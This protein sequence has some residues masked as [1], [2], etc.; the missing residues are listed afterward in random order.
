MAD[1][2]KLREYLK[3]AVADVREAR[4]RLQEVEDRQQEPIAIIGMGCHYPGNANTPDEL[5]HLITTTTD[6]IT[7]F[8]TNRG[9]HLDTLYHPDPDHPGTTYTQH[10]GFLHNADQFDAEFFNM[11]PREATA[12]DPQQRL[13]LHTAWETLEHAG[14]NPTTLH[15]T[16]T[17][18]FTGAMYS[19][20]GS[21]PDLPP[22]G[23][24]GHLFSGSAGSIASGRLAYTLGL[25]GPVV[26]VDTACSSSLVALHLAATAL[27]R[28]ECDLALAGGV[29]VMST[30]V[31]FVEFSRLRGL[32]DDGRCKSFSAHADGTGWSEGVGLLLVE[33]LTDALRH[34]HRVLAVV[35]GSAVNS[36][37]ASNGLTA[38]SG[39]AQERVIRRA[40]DAAGLR[41]AD[42]D[43]I[44]AHGTGT[45]LG[46]PIEAE[47]LAA[48]YGQ[49]HSPD[50]PAWLGSLKSNIGHTQAAAGVGG[51]IKVVQ[52]IRHGLLPPTLHADE[53]TPHVDWAT[54]GLALLTEARPWPEREGPR[55][56]AV[57][58]F[59]FG[60]TNAHVV[61][62]QAPE[63]PPATGGPLP[64][65]PW[66][67]SA[68]TADGLRA[69]VDRLTEFLREQ[70]DVEAGDVALSLAHRGS[71]PVRAVATGTDRAALLAALA[72]ATPTTAAAGGRTAF[73]FTGQGA[74]HAGM[75]RE[76]REAFPVFRAAFDEVCAALDPLLPRPLREVVDSGDGLD[77]TGYTQ[78]ALFA[79]ETA[80]YRLLTSWGITADLVAGHSV[81]ELTAA[82]VSGTLTLHD[83]ATLVAARARLMQALP[84]G[85]AMLAVEADEQEL[86]GWL[87]EGLDVAA[88]NGPRAVVL[89]GD[90]DGIERARVE[91]AGRGRRVR[92]LTVS[93]AFH[94]A[95]MD[96]M[97]PALRQTAAT[98]SYAVPEIPAVSTVTGALVT[99]EWGDPGYW[100]GQ[101]RATVRFADAVATLRAQGATTLLEVGPDA[102][103][104]VL[105]EGA[106]P[107]CR[108]D[109]PE[110]Q[111]VVAAAGALWTRG[112]SVDWPAYFADA[113]VN[114]VDLPPYAFDNRRYW[115][116]PRPAAAD[117]A[118]LGLDPAGHPL[119]GAVVRRADTDEVLLTGRLSAD[120][121]PWLADHLLHGRVVVPGT[122]LL[123][124]AVRAADE[125]GLTTVGEL[126]LLAPLVVPDE[127]AAQVQVVVGPTGDDGSRRV[128][129]HARTVDTDWYPVATG[130]L[131]LDG[132]S[133]PEGLPHWPP[134]G[135]DEVDLTGAYDR[136]VAAGYT[137]GPAFRG[138]RRLWRQG[139]VRYAEVTV[140]DPDRFTIHPAL[141]DAALHPLLPGVVDD[142][143]ARMPFAWAGVRVRAAGATTLRVRLTP[144][145][146]DT[147]AVLVADG[148]GG[149]VATVDALSLRPL[150]VAADDDGPG[151]PGQLWSLRWQPADPVDPGAG[152]RW[153]LL[154]TGPEVASLAYADP[155]GTWPVHAELTELAQPPDVLIAVTPSDVADDVVAGTHATVSWA[156]GVSRRFLADDRY[157]D[158][159]LVVVT[160]GAVAAR[161][162]DSPTLTHAA[163]W[164]LLRSAQTE[165]PGRLT[166][167]DLDDDA[168]AAQLAGAVAGGEPQVAIRDGQLL[169]P[170][171]GPADGV[172]V[173][174]REDGATAAQ[175]RPPRFDEG[176][177]LV[178]GGTGVLGAMV[179][180]HLVTA[181]GARRL[182]LVSRA[183]DRAEGVAA[184][185]DELTALGAEVSFAGCDVADRDALAEVL[186]AVPSDRPL[187]AVVHTAGVTDDGVL[188]A[189][190]AEQVDAVLRPKVDAAWHLHQLTLDRELSAFVLYSSLAGLVGTA[191]QANYAA[192]N[193]FL[194]ALAAHR[195]AAGLPAVSLAWGL[196]EQSSGLTGRLAEADLRRLARSGLRPL[197]SAAG[198]AL[199]DQALSGGA[200]LYAATALDLGQLR[201]SAEPPV[202]LRGLVPAGRPSARAS[203]SPGQGLG[204]QLAALSVTER[205]RVVADL[206]RTRLAGVLG[207]ADAVALV[208]E[209]PL[210]ELG[211]DSLTAVELRNQL[212]AATGLTLPTTL[213][214]DHP[215]VGALTR[216]L[217]DRLTNTTNTTTAVT[218]T[219]THTTDE[220]IAIIGMGCHYP[221]NANT[222]DEL[223]HLITT[224]TDAITTFP[225]N[226]GWHLDTLYHPDPD[227]PGTTY[228]QHGG[229]LHNADQFDAEFFNM[230]PREATAT[231]PQQRLLLHTAWETLE[232]AGINPTTLHGTNTGVF[233]GTMYSDYGSRLEQLPQEL[234]G[235]LAG[236]SAASVAS[237]RI[238]YTLGLQ[239]PAITIDTA[240]S[241]SLV[242]LHLAATALRNHECDLALTGGATIMT[243]PHT[244]TEFARQRG[245]APD[246]RC[247]PF[248]THAD[249]TG[250]SEGAGLLLLQRLTDAQQ[251]GHHI[252]AIIRG[253]AINQDGASNGLTAPNG[254]AQQ[255]VIHQALHNA[256]LQP[257]DITLIEA[258]GT[259]TRLGDPIEAQALLATYGQHRDQPLW[260]GSL[261]SNL[262]HTQAAAG[263]G[264]IIKVIE[265]IRHATLPP[266]LHA[267][268]PTPHVDWTTGNIKLL[269]HA[270]PWPDTDRPRRA[271]VSSFGI[272]GTNAHVILE[273]PPTPPTPPPPPTT[274]PPPH[275]PLIISAHNHH[276]LTQQATRLHHHLTNHP[277][278]NPTDVAYSLTRRAALPVR[279]VVVGADREEILAG[280]GSVSGTVVPPQVRTAF[281]FTGQGAQRVGM[282][283]ELRETFPVFRAAFDEVCAALDPLLPRPLRDVVDSGDGLDDTGYTQPALFAFEVALFRLLSSWGVTPDFVAGHSIGELA[284]AHVAGVLSLTDAA[285]LV[286]AR[287]RLMQDLPAGGAMLAV[288]ATEAEVAEGQPRL[289][290]AAV[291]GP[292]S[293]VLAGPEAVVTEAEASWSRRGRRVR[294]LAVSHAFHSSLMTPMLE[295]FAE[296]ADAV[297]YATPRIPAVST[298]TGRPVRDEWSDG[299]YWTNQIRSTV[300][301]A[302]AVATLGE[303]G[304]TT[305][306]EIGPDTTLAALVDGAVATGHR[307][308]SETRSLVS[309]V[310][311]AWARGVPVDWAAWFAGTG[312]TRVELPRYAFQ[313][314]SYWAVAQ[315]QADTGPGRTATGHPLLG[316][317]VALAGDDLTFDSRISRRD[318]PWLEEV[319]PAAAL[320]ELVVEAGGRGGTPLLEQLTLSGP[321]VLPAEDTLALQVRVATPDAQGRRPVSVYVRPGDDGP[322]QVHGT[323]VLAPEPPESPTAAPTGGPLVAL[324]E[325]LHDEAGRYRLHPV[326]FDAAVHSDLL[327]VEAGTVLVPTGWRGV[328]LRHRGPVAVHADVTVLDERR[329]RVRL[330]DGD[331]DL[332]GTVDE[333][334][335][336][337]VAPQQL[338][339]AAPALLALGW[340]PAEMSTHR[341][342]GATVAELPRFDAPVAD[343]VH[344]AAGW[345]SDLL[346][347]VPDGRPLVVVT[348]GAVRVDDDDMPDATT[349]AVRELLRVRQRSAVGRFVLLDADADEVAPDLV[350]AV[351]GL[352]EPDVAVRRTRLY[353]PR[354]RHA[355]RPAGPGCVL[356]PTGTVLLTGAETTPGRI[357]AAQLAR[358]RD[359]GRLL[360]VGDARL[361]REALA[362]IL[363][364]VPPGEPLTAV[365]H[366][367]DDDPGEDL[368][369]HLDELLPGPGPAAFV[370]VSTLDN[371]ALAEAVARRRAHRGLPAVVVAWGPPA[372][373]AVHRPLTTTRAA[374]LLDAAFAAGPIGVEPLLPASALDLAAVPAGT[375][376][377]PVLR[378]LVPRPTAPATRDD[379]V[380]LVDRLTGLD[381]DAQERLVRGLVLDQAARAL[382]HVDAT[383]IGPDLPF[384]NAGM[385]SMTAVQLRDRLQAA[386]GLVLA[387]TLVFEQPTPAVLARYLLAQLTAGS[388][389]TGPAPSLSALLD[390]LEATVAARDDADPETPQLVARL[391]AV[392]TRLTDERAA[393][394]VDPTARLATASADEIFH[395]I[396][397][398]LGRRAD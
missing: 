316:A 278:L 188:T 27:R 352:D 105:A 195:R 197:S 120:T 169:V 213:A 325:H 49:D 154:G 258:H 100:A 227:H 52:A 125:T 189:L 308:T 77:D 283:R 15:G 237:G 135:A 302:D 234:Q 13:L 114:R 81:G 332:V 163:L 92:S 59:G 335:Y 291:N 16:N 10:G 63:Q 397:T 327:P 266:T 305:F 334:T 246:G 96:P 116:D 392:L 126:T 319:L 233:I 25:G 174:R 216:Y 366:A 145:S 357:L 329:V 374:T 42:V 33:R 176:T 394:D 299:G 380:R 398:E 152:R 119:L 263:V 78:P 61:L 343:A 131:T 259:G 62:E 275:Q 255:R 205:D 138:L 224:T 109:R 88:V 45:R 276:T 306:L 307:R 297:R 221:G 2:D 236:G 40:L 393:P 354:L 173:G 60:G 51:I 35:R 36:D 247:K 31:A 242:A 29:A 289:D 326:L 270:R 93:H 386:T 190:T 212:A 48:T 182:L 287:A 196:W 171:L 279:A 252:H 121:Q 178:T 32:A 390:R 186:R 206:V 175:A 95:L 57:S 265:A 162:G 203:A 113:A 364:D 177:V 218:R 117:S 159:R 155:G 104:S 199:F 107:T 298:V 243:Q 50:R 137:Y 301:F 228:T 148:A 290:V 257:H 123:E 23:F 340:Q 21:R 87:P 344:A 303:L 179:A 47:A 101:V 358:R 363:A 293:L 215:S 84:P 98:L 181:H 73:L 67:V 370:L 44:E 54:S 166:I 194:D 7:T 367:G 323:G 219:T 202:L 226:R 91:W 130:L 304:V 284:A 271:A 387:P 336:T 362:K 136:L 223:W 46:D 86:L 371:R 314:R 68:R 129:I 328:H 5:W 146:G 339:P 240:C 264:G 153:A 360:T 383:A 89:A 350:D 112:V 377:P 34:G 378:D 19:D 245:L 321:L 144:V 143:P 274:N 30:P 24:Q 361:G 251:Q 97:L 267:D 288:E 333:L 20:Y 347:T 41:P 261:K 342:G 318:L 395:L 317:A 260:L 55:R 356:D 72:T 193:A 8:P 346:D 200:A 382:G 18:V 108:R 4:R 348:R 85:G 309:A 14:I 64:V 229:F 191:G 209:R 311:T 207:H 239:G 337:A 151:R 141:L 38:P 225:T 83:A 217:L 79:F 281:L 66:L 184:L 204:T 28:G 250:W 241:S 118:G 142:L 368:P 3:R 157:A 115:L 222:P 11:S 39:P 158:S 385:D 322:W 65:T 345:L 164:G 231:D 208:A 381:P 272:S 187:R 220:P 160:R 198:L 90:E 268:E 351:L 341:P 324:P 369:V 353:V 128:D 12:T 139:D 110:P 201:R 69:Q 338:S 253:S 280:L 161:P 75:G 330:T 102:V 133:T 310:A 149:P 140:D 132:T 168:T 111:A 180:R 37:G 124:M 183:G 211:L 232:H 286:G 103:L 373:D 313:T 192:G 235:Y 277:H 156:L 315:T 238:A 99:G 71:L 262:G 58:S 396:D 285:T 106:V 384:Q 295:A 122:A 254:P 9:W 230:S 269:T 372:G 376:V 80:L 172:G 22:D 391:Q 94:S 256:G 150:A 294:R 147:V 244:F 249:G 388:A 320:T 26:T 167:V 170:R 70:P 248:S 17:G 210:Q 53:P 134:A 185:R 365:I 74:Q 312:A 379:G 359:V 296:T 273:Q 165:Q 389:G 349:G 56:A 292:R 331:G 375:D 127:G 214:F 6:A 43:L 1:E 355:T 300:R 282:G 76:L 82:Y